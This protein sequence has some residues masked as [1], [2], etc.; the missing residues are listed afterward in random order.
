MKIKD[1]LDRFL[2]CGHRGYAGKYPENT[3][4]AFIAAAELGVDLIELDVVSS[5]DGIPV[6][7]HDYE[8]D[9]TS[10]GHGLL[11]D[12]TL[13]ELRQFNMAARSDLAVRPERICT[14]EEICVLL[15][16]YPE[17]MLNIDM[18]EDDG[19]IAAKVADIV[20]QFGYQERVIFNGLNG[21]GL[22]A[23]SDRGFFVEAS[24]D[25]FYTMRHFDALFQDGVKKAQALCLNAN[26]DVNT[27]NV[28]KLRSYGVEVWAWCSNWGGQSRRDDGTWSPVDC[29]SCMQNMVDHG[30]T[31]ALCNHPDRCIQFLK[32]RGLR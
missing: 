29:Q 3:M 10:D 1:S 25:G 22:A 28:E 2:V 31:M 21:E 8:L 20:E 32:E 19:T 6:I 13:E 30:I 4:S 24:P 15:R 18:K 5:K 23:M 9:R 26:Q 11:A 17:L 7:C 27:E 12:Y 14:F 16:K